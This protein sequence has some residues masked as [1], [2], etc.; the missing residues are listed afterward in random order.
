MVSDRS[1]GPVE[2][3]LVKFGSDRP[4]GRLVDALADTLQNEA[5]RLIDLV[6]ISRNSNG[7][8]TVE[9]IEDV[10]AE[11]G[12]GTIELEASGIAGSEDIDELATQIPPGSAAAVVVIEHIW[13]RKLASALVNSGGEVLGAERIPAPVVN[14]LLAEMRS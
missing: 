10:S 5:V 1:Y 13:A 4:D 11:F 9:E 12:F 3:L 8:V 2:V 14:D 7:E 6:L